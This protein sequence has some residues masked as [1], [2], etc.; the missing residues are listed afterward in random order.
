MQLTLL[1]SLPVPATA[2]PPM[3]YLKQCNPGYNIKN[4]VRDKDENVLETSTGHHRDYRE[5]N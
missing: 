1:R 2:Q 5:A 3:V 4:H